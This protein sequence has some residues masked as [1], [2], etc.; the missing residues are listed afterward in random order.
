MRHTIPAG[1]NRRRVSSASV[2]LIAALMLLVGASG[3]GAEEVEKGE[4]D[5]KFGIFFKFK[6]DKQ[7]LNLK[8]GKITYELNPELG[9]K[10][11]G[12]KVSVI[13]A[14]AARVSP[15]HDEVLA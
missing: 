14:D 15:T 1:R 2:G 5:S 13:D 3:L 10:M 6:A 12:G 4:G 7:A 11:F 9:A 8:E